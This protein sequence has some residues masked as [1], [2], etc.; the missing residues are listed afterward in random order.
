MTGYADY[1]S[2]LRPAQS[3]TPRDR[4]EHEGSGSVALQHDILGGEMLPV[5]YDSCD[6]LYSE[7]AWRPGFEKF[8]RRAGLA[9]KEGRSYAEY[10]NAVSEIIKSTTQPKVMLAG[11]HALKGLPK[12]VQQIEG[13][14]NGGVAV[15]LTYDGMHKPAPEITA[16]PDSWDVLAVLGQMYERVG[17]F[18]CGYGRSGMVFAKHEGSFVMSDYN[19]MCIGMVAREA[20]GWFGKHG[21]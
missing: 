15:F 4:Y 5:E 7:I 11:K 10:L 21:D 19:R 13:T 17:D 2:A 3:V 1:H 20:E 9:D 6:V 18:C 8:N 14:L 12:P 16:N